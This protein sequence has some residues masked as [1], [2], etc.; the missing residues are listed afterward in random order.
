MI[1]KS[2]IDDILFGKVAT[3]I[4]QNLGAAGFRYQ[5]SKKQFLREH[6]GFEQVI[7]I[8]AGT[9][10]IYYDDAVDAIY[11]LFY[12]LP[13]LDY[14]AYEKWYFQHTGEHQNV[15]LYEHPAINLKAPLE[16]GDFSKD[17]FYSPT[18]S[19]QFKM[20]VAQSLSGPV[21]KDN[22]IELPEF[23]K[24][25]LITLITD[26]ADKCDVQKL[27]DARKY[28]LAHTF[29]L[30][31]AGISDLGNRQLDL[32]YE[33]Y[34]HEIT[35]KLKISDQDSVRYLQ[36]F[37]K[38][39]VHAEKLAQRTFS[40][41]F[42][43]GAKQ[44]ANQ[45]EHLKLS[46]QTTFVE[47]LRLDLSEIQ[48]R[49][50][51]IN[52][53]GELLLL[54]S[55]HRMLKL[56]QSGQVLL[57][58]KLQPLEGFEKFFDLQARYLEGTDEFFVN[59]FIITKDN[60]MLTLTLPSEK[61]KGKRL[62]SPHIADLAYLVREN[63]Y[64]IIHNGNLLTYT[65]D[66]MLE[67][68]SPTSARRIIAQKEWLLSLIEGKGVVITDF[69]GQLVGEFEY[70]HGNRH[71]TFSDDFQFMACYGYSTKSQF[72]DL[73]N[74]K[75]GTLWAHPT[76]VKDYKEVMYNDIENNFGMEISAFSP[77]NKYLVG[78]AYHGKYAAWIL[79]KLDRT[80]LIPLPETFELLAKR[81][82]TFSE[83]GKEER[84]IL[85]SIVEL[86]GQVF[87]K[88]RG[89][90]PVSIFF[91]DKGDTFCM[92]IPQSNLLLI[93]DRNFQNT[94]HLKL[95]GAILLHGDDYIT[96]FDNKESKHEL[97]IYRKYS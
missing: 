61:K 94:D 80:E 36:H 68:T 83:N 96:R 50:Y 85:P 28:P 81:D 49:S 35:A 45:N 31:F 69:Q 38:F 89:N 48:V 56:T 86:E 23:M 43:R 46:A 65:R 7:K 24:G 26:L 64:L 88:N 41:P 95:A 39:I 16:F 18:A 93:W 52:S 27:F 29:L 66:G 11:L 74:T 79:P 3:M 47:T 6:N 30:I 82:I 32:T 78:A 4:E 67:N 76:Y 33:H 84:L 8:G 40:N 97:I 77:D 5:K 51:V 10:A 92:S 63:K 15:A 90:V 37:D 22:F 59:N 57:D 72:Y 54:T 53:E 87:F 55:D 42:I 25:Q 9:R 2:T 44:L 73:K 70:G 12:M 1:K 13:G 14:P 20:N 34:V 19:Q 60:K 71:C 91:I 75:R 58:V 17:D 21:D 62:P